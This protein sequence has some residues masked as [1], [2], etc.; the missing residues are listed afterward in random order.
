MYLLVLENYVEYLYI[1]YI[2]VYI[3]FSTIIYMHIV[4]SLYFTTSSPTYIWDIG[5][6]FLEFAADH[7]L[8][9]LLHNMFCSISVLFCANSQKYGFRHPKCKFDLLFPFTCCVRVFGYIVGCI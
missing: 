5:G 4:V 3:F 8:L 9:R 2:G 1:F 6:I 7:S